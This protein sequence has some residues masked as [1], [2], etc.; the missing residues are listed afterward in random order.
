MAWWVWLILALGL[1][2]AEIFTLSFGVL[3]FGLAALGAAALSAVGLG[4]AW[5][6]GVFGAGG[7]VLLVFTRPLV[8]RLQPRDLPTNVDALI[9]QV[10]VVDQELGGAADPAGYVRLGGERWRAVA[11][12]PLPAGTRVVVRRVEG[13]TLRVERAGALEA[14][15]KEGSS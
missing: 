7:L 5:Q 4:P 8:R 11:P 9:G 13:V 12:E 15:R 10:A 6:L 14:D 1:M 2:G 3:W